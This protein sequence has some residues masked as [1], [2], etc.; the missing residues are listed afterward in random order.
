M[1][2]RG[3]PLQLII[4]ERRIL[5]TMGDWY[6]FCFYHNLDHVLKAGRAMIYGPVGGKAISVTEGHLIIARARAP[7]WLEP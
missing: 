2:V 3:L 4:P 5:K 1:P 7:G 6:Q